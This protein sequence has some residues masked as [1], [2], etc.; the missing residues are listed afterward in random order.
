MLVDDAGE[1]TFEAAQR[2]FGRVSGG[3]PLA[4][5]PVAEAVVEADLGDG[6]AVQGGVELAVARSGQ[7][8]PAGGVARPDRD[9]EHRCG[10]Q[11]RARF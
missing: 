2:F 5:V 10:G 11:R 9:R 7:A 4:V 6:D 1:S 3:E 8:D